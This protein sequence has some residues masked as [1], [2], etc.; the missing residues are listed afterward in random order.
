MTALAQSLLCCVGVVALWSLVSAK[1]ASWRV[2]APLAIASAGAVVGWFFG[3]EIVTVLNYHVTEQIVELVLAALLFSDSLRVEG[4][5]LGSSPS[6]SLRLLLLAL[7][8][9]LALAASASWFLLPE[10]GFAV[11]LLIACVIM[12]ID[13]AP[14][15]AIL[16]DNRLTRGVRSALNVESGYNDGVVA[17]IFVFALAMITATSVDSVTTSIGKALLASTVSL[18]VGSAIG[19]TFGWAMKVALRRGWTTTS[20]L[21]IGVLAVPLVT[22]SVAILLH[23]NGFVAAFVAGVAVHLC[24]RSELHPHTALTEQFVECTSLVVWFVFGAVAA[25]IVYLGLDWR[26]VVISVLALTVVRLVPVCLAL[27][28]SRLGVVDRLASSILGPRGITTIVLGLLAFNALDDDIG[29][30]VLQAMIVTISLSL[31]MH[32]LGSSFMVRLLSRARF[33]SLHTSSALC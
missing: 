14:A 28:G 31:L 23:G 4:K 24:A 16:T 3:P 10:Y 33:R 7:P 5:M 15:T 12:P 22:F 6:V 30:I 1:L 26:I 13:M 29:L 27:V 17:P 20:S 2:S 19:L 32:G 21:S 11:A 8:L 25:Y 9:S 18:L